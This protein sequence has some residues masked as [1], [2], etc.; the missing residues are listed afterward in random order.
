MNALVEDAAQNARLDEEVV[1]PAAAEEPVGH[2]VER[3]QLDGSA[4]LPHSLQLRQVVRSLLSR[5]D[6]RVHRLEG[7]RR[8]LP[9]DLYSSAEGEGLL[10]SCAERLRCMCGSPKSKRSSV[11]MFEVTIRDERG[12]NPQRTARLV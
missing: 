8:V 4:H 3:V 1:V 5:D 7:G 2:H 12:E 9:R 11:M 6:Q 10:S